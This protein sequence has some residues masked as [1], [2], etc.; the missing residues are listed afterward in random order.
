MTH[1]TDQRKPQSDII[2][3]AVPG[4]VI[5]VTRD[6]HSVALTSEAAALLAQD[7]PV[8]VDLSRAGKKI[9]NKAAL[10]VPRGRVL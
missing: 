2:H 8:L 6:G 9:K 1:K 3:A 5:I 10:L 7:L 4:A